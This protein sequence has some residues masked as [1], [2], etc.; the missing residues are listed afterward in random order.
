MVATPSSDTPARVDLDVLFE[1]LAIPSISQDPTHRADMTLAAEWLAGQLDFAQGRVVDT[2]GHPVVVGAY[3][4]S[5]SA[6]TFLVYGHYD[7]QP[8]GD[9]AQWETPPFSPDLRNGRIYARGATDDKCPLY[10]AIDAA[11]ALAASGRSLPNLVF[12]LEGEEEIGSPSLAGT[13]AEH[14][15][16]GSIAG[17]LSADG[18]MWR[19]T[20]PSLTT[21]AKGVA[22]FTLTV[23]GPRTDLHSGRYGGAVANPNHALATILTSLHHPDGAIAVTGFYD[24]ARALTPSERAEIA[25]IPFDDETY[26]AS[27]GVSALAGEPGFSTLE[28]LWA[29]PTLEV[30]GIAGGGS[31]TVIPA[32]A[33]AHLTCRLVPDQE[34]LKIWAALQ[35]H[36][37]RLAPLGVSCSVTPIGGSV[38]AYQLGTNDALFEAGFNALREVYDRDPLCVRMGG[39]L[40]AATIFEETLSTK[41]L[42]FSFSVSDENLHAPNEFFRVE[43]LEEGKHAWMSL[44]SLLPVG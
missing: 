29:R 16:P 3:G 43:R 31:F 20:E 1:F 17:V 6:P 25:A 19:V 42:L 7:V 37:A 35:A 14:W 15:K 40:P 28:R 5:A 26:R 36:V 4:S 22:A 18:A 2:A 27:I 33:T 30:N 11:R 44:L 32:H 34:P 41:T 24:D 38:T 10:I 12:L 21:A 23:A 39:T 9:L 8:P 13:L